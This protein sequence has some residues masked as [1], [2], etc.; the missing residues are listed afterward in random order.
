MKQSTRVKVC[1]VV[2]DKSELSPFSCRNV[3][4][5]S[6]HSASRKCAW[7]PAGC[8]LPAMSWKEEKIPA[9][10]LLGWQ[11]GKE[12]DASGVSLQWTLWC[13]GSIVTLG[14][15]YRRRLAGR[16]GCGW[17]IDI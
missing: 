12:V 9:G 17:M 15:V 16:A 8:H 4:R 13:L 2:N 5:P 6:F 1:I 11:G 7:L 3:K 10:N 14:T